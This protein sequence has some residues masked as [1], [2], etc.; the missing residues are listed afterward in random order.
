MRQSGRR[1]S[2]PRNWRSISR[3]RPIRSPVLRFKTRGSRKVTM[4]LYLCDAYWSATTLKLLTDEVNDTDHIQYSVLV[5]NPVSW[6]SC[7]HSLTHKIHP[8]HY[9]KVNSSWWIFIVLDTL[10][11]LGRPFSSGCVGATGGSTWSV[12]RGMVCVNWQP[13]ECQN[14]GF[15]CS[16]LNCSE[17]INVTHFYCRW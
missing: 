6:C 3:L 7:G 1:C 4:E 13:C 15:P 10:V 14:P 9:F 2:M 8:K 12:F 16:I 5:G 11:L 17:M